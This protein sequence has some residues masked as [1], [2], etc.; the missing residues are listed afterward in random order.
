VP[1]ATRLVVEQLVGDG[2]LELA[3]ERAVLT[4]RGR[5]LASDVTTRILLATSTAGSG[6][7]TRYH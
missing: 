7:G 1:A 6:A 5:L 3:G 4:R 2:L